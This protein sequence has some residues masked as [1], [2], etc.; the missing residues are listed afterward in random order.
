MKERWRKYFHIP[1]EGH[2]SDRVFMA[3]LTVDICLIL[4]YMACMLY[5]AL[6]LF[7]CVP[8]VTV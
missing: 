5:A 3:R 2:I 6:T 8:S 7:Q 1:S 4:L